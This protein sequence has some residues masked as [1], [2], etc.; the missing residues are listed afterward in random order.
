MGMWKFRHGPAHRSETLQMVG[1]LKNALNNRLGG[2][3]LIERNV[4]GDRIKL[5]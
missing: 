3:R 2:F 5:N 4:L 1:D